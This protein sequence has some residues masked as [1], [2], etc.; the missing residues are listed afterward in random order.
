MSM[1]ATGGPWSSQPCAM[2]LASGSDYSTPGSPREVARR[3]RFLEGLAA[4]REAGIG[5]KV[6][7]RVEG[8]FADR[9]FDPDR[10]AVVQQLPALLVIHQVGNHDLIQNLFVH[11]RIEDR[12]QRL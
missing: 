1:T 2:P 4:A 12:A 8:F 3:R 7:V 9:R 10:R 6:L 5:H 11:S